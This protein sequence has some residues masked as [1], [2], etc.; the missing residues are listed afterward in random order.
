MIWFWLPASL[1][2]FND[3]AAWFWG[4]FCSSRKHSRSDFY[5][6]ITF[7]RTQLFALS[8]KKTV[9]GFVGAFF[10]TCILGFFW[11]TFFMQYD[12]MIC[13]VKDLGTSAW[14]GLTCKPNLVFVWREFE[15]AKPAAAFLSMLVSVT[16]P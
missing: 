2:I 12:Y 4:A 3:V 10:T 14:S 7:G 15:I 8:P 9:E 5:I 11:A 13:P 16:L 6:G 1:V